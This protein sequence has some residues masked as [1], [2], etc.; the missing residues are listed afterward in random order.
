MS[1]GKGLRGILTMRSRSIQLPLRAETGRLRR[2]RT[3]SMPWRVAKS[4]LPQACSSTPSNMRLAKSVPFGTTEL[5]AWWRKAVAMAHSSASSHPFLVPSSTTCYPYSGMTCYS[6]S[7]WSNPSLAHELRSFLFRTDHTRHLTMMSLLSPLRSPPWWVGRLDCWVLHQ[8][9]CWRI[10]YC[11][12]INGRRCSGASN[13]QHWR[14]YIRLHVY[15]LRTK[16]TPR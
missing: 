15:R 14:Y 11:V 16:P 4:Q 3:W 12:Q 9:A 10:L 5:W 2:Q 6:R 8:S 7:S 13:K 1:V